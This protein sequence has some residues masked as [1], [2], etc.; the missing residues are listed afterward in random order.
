[1]TDET[2]AL[3]EQV[4][5]LLDKQAIYEVLLGIARGVDRF[6]PELLAACI[7]PDAALDMGSET[8]IAGAA[9]AAALKPPADPPVGRMHLIAN[10]VI[11]VD[12][13]QARAESY[14]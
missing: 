13:D 7:H 3:L 9:F 5:R 6:D 4:A 2:Q 10:P 8:P 14:I 1:M 12:G 11:E